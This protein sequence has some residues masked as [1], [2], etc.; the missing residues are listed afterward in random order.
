M[1]SSE[2]HENEHTDMSYLSDIIAEPAL[3]QV[4]SSA[5]YLLHFEQTIRINVHVSFR[6]HTATI[7]FMGHRAES[8]GWLMPISDEQFDK[9]LL[10]DIDQLFDMAY[11][12]LIER[13]DWHRTHYTIP[14]IDIAP[15]DDSKHAEN[16]FNESV[17]ELA[18]C[19]GLL[20]IAT[21]WYMDDPT[22]PAD[23]MSHLAPVCIAPLAPIFG[24]RNIIRSLNDVT[25]RKIIEQ[26][27]D[28][29][30]GELSPA[31]LRVLNRNLR[32]TGSFRATYCCANLYQLCGA[33]LDYMYNH[34]LDEKRRKRFMLRECENCNHFF[35][36]VSGHQKYC[37]RNNG[38][39][40]LPCAKIVAN[41]AFK[42][43]VTTKSNDPNTQLY[44]SIRRRLNA[45]KVA[46]ENSALPDSGS[47]ITRRENLCERW[48]AENKRRKSS[49]NYGH[50]LS[51]A[52]EHL[53]KDKKEGY[54]HFVEWLSEQE[55]NSI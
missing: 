2:K 7:N 14:I 1:M 11:H 35:I 17:K 36:A 25:L 33:I 40:G 15:E 29:T 31:M 52:Q 6:D 16:A 34:F 42:A 47:E 28:N 30:C 24:T 23:T 19:I 13:Y 26:Y 51:I 18:T 27:P 48:K 3:E 12:T 55:G 39:D 49:P 4:L 8:D 38:P 44:S 20:V 37:T 43:F 9:P 41:D 21:K 45:Y 46:A 10:F 5:D 54:E 32:A 22:I 50:W 53:P